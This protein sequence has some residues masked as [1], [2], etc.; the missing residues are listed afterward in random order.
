MGW[1]QEIKNRLTGQGQESDPIKVTYNEGTPRTATVE[2]I[3]NSS[4][5]LLHIDQGGK[6]WVFSF[7]NGVGLAFSPKGE[8]IVAYGA[9]LSGNNNLLGIHVWFK[10]RY[11]FIIPGK[12]IDEPEKLVQT[13]EPQKIY[14]QNPFPNYSTDSVSIL[15]VADDGSLFQYKINTVTGRKYNREEVI[16]TS[17]DY[18]RRSRWK[19]IPPEF[20]PVTS[21]S[22]SY[23]V[24]NDGR[25]EFVSVEQEQP[26]KNPAY[27]TQKR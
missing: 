5:R 1:L 14:Q 3:W 11:K 27:R 9:L 15:E 21:S 6:S 16:N 13:K 17:Y 25:H 26:M 12:L 19:D 10:D 18:F 24:T 4:E 20:L 8:T 22:K 2:K 23:I 7:N